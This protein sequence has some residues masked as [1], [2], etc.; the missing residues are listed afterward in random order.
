MLHKMTQLQY[1]YKKIQNYTKFDL[2]VN[3]LQNCFYLI[4]NR[5]WAQA[6]EILSETVLWNSK[7]NSDCA[8]NVKWQN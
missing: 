7:C 6:R 8:S 1:E 2:N 4:H 5:L 3:T